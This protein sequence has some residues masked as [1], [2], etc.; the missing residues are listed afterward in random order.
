MHMFCHE[1][2]FVME[3]LMPFLQRNWT[4]IDL[5]EKP[6][7]KRDGRFTLDELLI[8]PICRAYADGQPHPKPWL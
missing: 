4:V 6:S 8:M 3:T 7:N 2:K 1:H 5:P